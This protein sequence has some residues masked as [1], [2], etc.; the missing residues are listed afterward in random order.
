MNSR[1]NDTNS[2][3]RSIGRVIRVIA[4]HQ[5]A[6]PERAAW[7]SDSLTVAKAADITKY[8]IVS[9]R[10][11]SA[12]VI[13]QMLFRSALP[14]GLTSRNVQKNPIPMMIP[15]MALGKS[16]RN[17]S[18]WRSLNLDRCA[19]AVASATTTAVTTAPTSAIST[20][21]R[22]EWAIVPRPIVCQLLSVNRCQGAIIGVSSVTTEDSASAAIG[23]NV[24]ATRYRPNSAPS[25]HLGTAPNCPSRTSP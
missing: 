19:T 13:P 12:S 20:V 2:A 23:A 6:P 5:L 15:G 7:S 4:V 22:I 3:G 10:T 17:G 14:G 21:F 24:V 9:E 18:E 25:T 11:L 16:I 1:T 8:A